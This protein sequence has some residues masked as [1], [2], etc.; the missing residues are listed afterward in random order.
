M[1]KAFLFLL[2]MAVCGNAF[3]Q[4]ERE[5]AEKTSD[6]WV[7]V[8]LEDRSGV[9]TADDAG[10]SKAG[11]V[12]AV[13]PVTPQH[14]PS[15]TEKKEWMI[16]KTSLTQAQR[17]S[18]LDNWEEIQTDKTTF[19]IPKEYYEDT[20]KR[21][22]FLEGARVVSVASATEISKTVDSKTVNVYRVSATYESDKHI[23][24]RK[25]K[26]DTSKL[27]V[28]VK[29]GLVAEKIDASKIK[30]S[31]KTSADLSKYELKRKFYAY[32]QRPLKIVS[33]KIVG[34]A[35]AETVSTCNKSGEDYNNITLWEDAKDG[36]LVTATS[37]ETLELYN[38]D[39]A[40]SDKIVI[41]GSTTNSSYYMKVTAPT[42]ERHNGTFGSGA[43]ITY[44]TS[45]INETIISIEDNYTIFEWITISGMTA[46]DWTTNN[47]ISLGD[48]NSYITIRYNL[49]GNTNLSSSKSIGSCIGLGSFGSATNILIYRN[50]IAN[51]SANNVQGI[52]LGATGNPTS[53]YVYN[54]T[55]YNL[56]N[57]VGT[58]VGISCQDESFTCSN[59]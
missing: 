2:M 44:T 9:T 15:E 34:P 35:F 47:F 59:N 19:E 24:Y 38:D 30:T 56:D 42:A 22:E 20:A 57:G 12:V 4:V 11:D 23:A 58:D 26:L 52:F 43:T 45:L 32:V 53:A 37:Q 48:A 13:L 29:V 1:K 39:G 17:N 18:L 28:P 55:V 49:I 21:A 3:A 25:N 51:V 50:I 54:N 31:V 10:R 46:D 5:P 41:D 16:F 40:L 27:G 14:I 7:Y 36:D 8:R 6:Y 33:N